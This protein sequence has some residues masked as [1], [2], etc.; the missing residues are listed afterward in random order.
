[1][2]GNLQF[3]AN[4]VFT[5]IKQPNL[6]S[7]TDFLN[8]LQSDM[9]VKSA[10]TVTFLGKEVNKSI[11]YYDKNAETYFE[12]TKNADMESQ[13]KAFLKLLP[14][15][16]KILDAGCGSGRDSKNFIDKGYEVTAIDASREL[17]KKASSFI[18]QE[19][20]PLKFN[21]FR[22]KNEFD[23]VWACASLVHIPKNEFEDSLRPLIDSLK[24]GGHLYT[25]LKLGEGESEDDKGRHF[26]Y[27]SWDELKAVIAK[28]PDLKVVDMFANGDSLQR[29]NTG[30]VNIIAKKSH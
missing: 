11:D 30:W 21:E 22:V 16:A 2:I 24:D 8:N 5:T 27:Y 29:K 7:K 1:M 12:T 26:S 23:G 6:Q 17:A 3:V 28:Q 18:G 19:V 9:F 4:K 15:N 20:L 10:R 14:A 13:Y 25:C